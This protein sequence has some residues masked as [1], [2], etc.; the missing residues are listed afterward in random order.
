MDLKRSIEQE[1]IDVLEFIQNWEN[2]SEVRN[3]KHFGLL[4]GLTSI[5]V[6]LLD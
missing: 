4:S 1:V 6:V 3:A 2:I 5:I